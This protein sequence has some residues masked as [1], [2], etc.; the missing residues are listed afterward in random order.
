[1]GRVQPVEPPSPLEH[2]VVGGQ[3]AVPA[4]R[5]SDDQ[6]IGWVGMEVGEFNGSNA[7]LTHRPRESRS[8]PVPTVPDAKAPVPHGA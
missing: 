5:S 6:P 3:Q 4:K 7:H 8:I 1:M 2:A